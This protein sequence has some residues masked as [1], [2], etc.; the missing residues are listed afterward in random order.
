MGDEGLEPARQS[1]T[2]GES[3]ASAANITAVKVASADLLL[4]AI[5]ASWAG[6][7]ADVQ[8]EIAKLTGG[9]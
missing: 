1:S 3:L 6:L 7:P 5:Q 2:S 8:A 4:K 9:K